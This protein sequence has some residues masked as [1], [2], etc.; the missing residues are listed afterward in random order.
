GWI[1]GD[2]HPLA[3]I[4]LGPAVVGV[5]G[6]K[7][8]VARHHRLGE[9]ER[10]IALERT[11]LALEHGF[12]RHAVQRGLD[13]EAPQLTQG[14]AIGLGVQYCPYDRY[15]LV[16]SEPESR[17]ARGIDVATG[18]DGGA[19]VDQSVVTLVRLDALCQRGS[20]T[21]RQ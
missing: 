5:D 16:T 18:R 1:R 2:E 3:Q 11:E 4:G 8:G 15:R 19:A 6:D 17:D 7:P 10:L 14:V 21:S 20:E 13:A 9:H 12:E